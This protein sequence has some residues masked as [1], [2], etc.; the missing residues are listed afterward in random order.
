MTK[1]NKNIHPPGRIKIVAAFTT[2]LQARDFSAITTAEIARTARVTEGLIYK[3]FNSKR[4]LLFQVLA[5]SFSLFI[6]QTSIELEKTSGATL[7]LRTLVRCYLTAYDRDRVLARM[8]MLEAR[9]STDFFKS[10]AY[11]LI[12]SHNRQ[13]IRIIAK[14]IKEGEIRADISPAVV[15]RIIFGAIEHAMLAPILF[16]RSVDVHRMTDEICGIVFNGICGKK[17]QADVSGV[18]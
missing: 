15:L 3:Y 13:V 8:L 17:V 5:E 1:S 10:N 11:N 2:L 16:G 7:R 14:G 9:N 18:D 6:N 4:D 12:R